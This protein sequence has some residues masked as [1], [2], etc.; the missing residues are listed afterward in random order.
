MNPQTQQSPPTADVVSSNRRHGA[1]S[2]RLRFALTGGAAI[3]LLGCGAAFATATTTHHTPA[4]DGSPVQ[5]AQKAATTGSD[6]LRSTGV[7]TV[8]LGDVDPYRENV[9]RPYFVAYG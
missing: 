3:A 4:T 7:R 2:P 8:G 5:H 1:R 9:K 6:D